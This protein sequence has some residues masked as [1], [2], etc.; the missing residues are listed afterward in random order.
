MNLNLSVPINQLGYG[1][2]GS[3]LAVALKR[4]MQDK[5]CIWPIG[6]VDSDEEYLNLLKDHVANTSYF[7]VKDPSYKMFHADQLV[8]HPSRGKWA[9]STF[10]ELDT[11][12]KREVC[13]LNTLDVVFAF[14]EWSKQVMVDN[15]VKTNIVVIKIGVDKRFFFPRKSPAS[16]KTIFINC[17]KWEIRKGHDIL[18]S[19]FNQAFDPEDSV[20]LWMMNDNPFLSPEEQQQWVNM[21]KN[22]KLGD[23]VKIVKRV[24]TQ[25]DVS[26][27]FSRVDCGVFP[28]RAE[29]WNLEASE[30]L[31][32][33]KDLII[34]NCTAQSDYCNSDNAMLIEV[35][36]KE[37]AF[38][39]K[40]FFGQGNWYQVGE[41]QI[42]QTADYMREYHKKKMNNKVNININGV[43]AMS[44]MSY[45]QAAKDIVR[46]LSV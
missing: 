1:I 22:S 4:E 18:V 24:P 34:T 40:W 35:G 25:K 36:P 41:S 37:K 11:L 44:E 6:P 46:N 21:Y 42:K 39:G 9:G 20:E 30:L 31:A 45:A 38:D 10:F 17:G 29:G 2:V 7:D 23:K 28:T 19:A 27:V 5:L 32:M 12:S 43:V 15:G 26:D 8:M 13:F 33:G 14:G 16:E 3:N